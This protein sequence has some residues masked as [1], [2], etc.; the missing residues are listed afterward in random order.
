M[1]G[2]RRFKMN[3]RNQLTRRNDRSL[4]GI[5]DRY[6][7][8]FFSPYLEEFEG[9]GNQNYFGNTDFMP[10]IEVKETKKGY[11][12]SAELPGLKE[13]DIELSLEGNVLILQGEKREEKTEDEEGR[14]RSEMSY[15]RFYRS[16]PLQED[17]DNKHID[18]HYDQGV[19]KINLK[20]KED[21]ESARRKIPINKSGTK[22]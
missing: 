10:K 2:T 5:F 16:I 20:K 13:E 6:A 18:A 3:N 17:V 9:D 15:G 8:D 21:G 4:G 1:E 14:W 19:L 22:H 12:V 7:R 11:R